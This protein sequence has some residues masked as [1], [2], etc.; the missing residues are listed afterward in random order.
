MPTQSPTVPSV[1]ILGSDKPVR[2]GSI[3]C[4]GRTYAAH[5]AELNNPMPADP[6]IFLKSAGTLRPLAQGDL[7]FPEE[8]FHHEAELTLLIGETVGLNESPPP[9]AI[10][11]VGLGLDLT[12]RE[13]QQE[14]KEKGLPWTAAKSFAGA[15]IMT[16]F[17][18]RDRFRDLGDIRFS[19]AVNGTQRQ[20]G[21]SSQMFF[22]MPRLLNHLTRLVP[23]FPGDIVFTGTPSGVGPVKRGD[24]VRLAFT[25]L[26]LSFEGQL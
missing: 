23:L 13:V 5:A 2:A 25:D 26:D 10:A 17:V 20:V 15:A 7:A 19:C 14:L 4:F 12:R 1:T 8:T 11:A 9:G 22:S 21:D 3:Y 18:P 24:H 16:P 6:I